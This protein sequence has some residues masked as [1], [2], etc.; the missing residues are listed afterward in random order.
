MQALEINEQETDYRYLG[1]RMHLTPTEL[2]IV[3]AL[4]GQGSCEADALGIDCAATAS[5]HVCSI[6]KKAQS[7]GGRRLICKAKG[8]GYRLCDDI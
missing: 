7:I 4:V 2:R 1:Y 5:V 8:R 3:R 6:N